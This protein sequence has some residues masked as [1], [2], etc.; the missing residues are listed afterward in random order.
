M[1]QQ[2]PNKLTYRLR[3]GALVL[4][5]IYKGQ[6]RP[7]AYVN[8]AGA[9]ASAA[10]HGGTVFQPRPGPVFYVRFGEGE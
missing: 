6:L 10:R 9:A 5:R 4:G 2:V 3:Q 1:S 8:R 7:L